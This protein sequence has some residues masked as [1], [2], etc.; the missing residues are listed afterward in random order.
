MKPKYSKNP[1]SKNCQGIKNNK[2]TRSTINKKKNEKEK[3]KRERKGK[4]FGR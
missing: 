3:T 1:N 2:L 4:D